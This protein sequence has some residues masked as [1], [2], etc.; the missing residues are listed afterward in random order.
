MLKGRTALITGSSTGLGLG[1]AEAFAEAGA[2]VAVHGLTARAEGAAIAA[3]LAEKYGVRAIFDDTDLTNH[4]SIPDMI[5]RIERK[6]GPLDIVVNNAVVRHFHS[7]ED[8]PAEEWEQAL[9]V[10]LSAAFHM[11]KYCL[12]PMKARGWGRIIN[13]SSIYGHRGIAGRIGYVTTKTALLGMTR[14]IAVE[15]AGSG[16]TCNALCP[17][18]VLTAPIRQRIEVAAASQKKC[19]E[20][21]ARAYAEER[22]P[23]GEFVEPADVGAMAVFLCG[24]NSAGVTGASLQ[25]DGGWLAA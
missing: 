22:H 18:S 21:V 2:D 4:Q 17:G 16:V 3:R 8:Y 24:P 6:L 15:V 9:S 23:T 12:G 13:L 1:L 25:M 5:A 20:E 19:F 10:N 7:V 14:A 11:A